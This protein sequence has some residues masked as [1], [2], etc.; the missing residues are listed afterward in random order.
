MISLL[1]RD[2]SVRKLR[3]KFVMFR[4]N[5][6]TGADYE[7]PPTPTDFAGEHDAAFAHFVRDEYRRG[8]G[9][10][11]VALVL[12]PQPTSRSRWRR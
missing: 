11:P 6:Y 5:D 9:S 8:S 10:D 12:T 1:P 4:T 7:A 3:R 2:V